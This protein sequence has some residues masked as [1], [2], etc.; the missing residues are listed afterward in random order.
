MHTV[1]LHNKLHGKSAREAA[2]GKAPASLKYSIHVLGDGTVKDEVT[3]S[4]RDLKVHPAGARRTLLDM[5]AI[6]DQH[7]LEI[8]HVEHKEDDGVETWLFVTQRR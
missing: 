2:S 6:I 5:L 7:R 4:V 8:R 1:I 3:Q